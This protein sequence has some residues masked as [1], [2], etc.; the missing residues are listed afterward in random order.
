MSEKLNPFCKIINPNSSLILLVGAGISKDKPSQLP[1]GQDFINSFYNFL[2]SNDD[3]NQFQSCIPQLKNEISLRFEKIMSIIERNYKSKTYS[4][5]QC[6]REA[7]LFNH[8]HR[9][10]AELAKIGH[11]VTTTNFDSLIE[12]STSPEFLQSIVWDDDYINEYDIPTV[13]KLHG[14]FNR[15]LLDKKKWE[16]TSESIKLTLEQVGLQGYGFIMSANK[17]KFLRTHLAQRDLVVIGYSGSDDFDIIPTL[18]QTYSTKKIIWIEYSNT[19]EGIYSFKDAIKNN[20]FGKVVNI[21]SSLINSGLRNE[22]AC[23]II[24]GTSTYCLDAIFKSLDISK[25]HVDKPY[26]DDN[27]DNLYFSKKL[28]E[29]MPDINS[30]IRMKA[31]LFYESGKYKESLNYYKKILPDISNSNDQYLKSKVLY[32]IAMC[33][34]NQNPSNNDSALKYAEQSYQLDIENKFNFLFL[35]GDLLARIYKNKRE[36]KKAIGIFKTVCNTLANFEGEY[37][38]YQRATLLGNYAVLLFQIG[39]YE[40]AITKKRIAGKLFIELGDLEGQVSTAIGLASALMETQKVQEALEELRAAEQIAI[41]L[42]NDGKLCSIYNE[43]GIVLRYANDLDSAIASH[44]KAAQYAKKQN[45]NIELARQFYNL[46]LCEYVKKD[47]LKAA[48]SNE[49]S[50]NLRKMIKVPF[51]HAMGMAECF[52]METNLFLVRQNFIEAKKS[53]EIS[54]QYGKLINYKQLLKD[55]ERIEMR[56]YFLN[57]G[58]MNS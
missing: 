5:L 55:N 31:M 16:D 8:N 19:E 7:N 21:L 34:L 25:P 48:K 46:A 29:V 38:K 49:E 1:T 33:Y 23:F 18:M 3:D 6:Y 13:Y 42:G 26:I 39:K 15:Y 51:Q 44:K 30:V 52:Q 20:S 22:D 9:L 41:N 10:I 40:E 47:F 37:Y 12:R 11:I 35:S 24:R 14:S 2:L 17:S 28:F 4:L 53:L 54:N 58:L 45:N 32:E 56:I 50:L 27:C 43:L 57:G 36:I